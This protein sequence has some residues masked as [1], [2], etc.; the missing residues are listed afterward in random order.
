MLV[1]RKMSIMALIFLCA[2]FGTVA[3]PFCSR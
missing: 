3:V 1:K 2:L